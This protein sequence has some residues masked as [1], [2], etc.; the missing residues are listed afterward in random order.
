MVSDLK[1]I[2]LTGIPDNWSPVRS[3]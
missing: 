2:K 3:F 1:K